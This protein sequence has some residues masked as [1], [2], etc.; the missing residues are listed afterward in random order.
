VSTV[1]FIADRPRLERRARLLAW[2]GNAW[3]L[4]EFAIA[5]GAGVAAGSVALVAF[6]VDSLI[7]V[8]AG[9]TIVWRSPD[10]GLDRRRPSGARNS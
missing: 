4:I 9:L 10:R 8:A 2:G 6:G 5:L 3:H 7:E 1:A